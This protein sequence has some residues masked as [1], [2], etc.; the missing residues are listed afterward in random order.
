MKLFLLIPA[1][2]SWS[3]C[4]THDIVT[5]SEGGIEF[6]VQQFHD[7]EEKRYGVTFTNDDNGV[8]SKF[9]MSS[10]GFVSDITANSEKYIVVFS[11]N[12]DLKHVRRT[13]SGERRKTRGLTNTVLAE[14][15]KDTELEY[16]HDA[17]APGNHEIASGRGLQEEDGSQPSRRRLH[18]C[19]KCIKAWDVVCDI[20][21]PS[22]C[23]LV[24]YG[25][26]IMKYGEASI[27]TMCNTFGAACTASEGQQ[28]CSP[29][30]EDGTTGIFV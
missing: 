15:M 4:A 18:A 16:V 30:C 20:G 7:H 13:S 26:P 10:A 1:M 27:N 8:D 12:G 23:L 21:V 19:T 2:I 3:A 9:M 6:T 28:A 14:H 11:A 29:Y 22:V 17:I 25:S 24:D 5:V